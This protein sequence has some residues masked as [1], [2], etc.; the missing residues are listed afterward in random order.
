MDYANVAAADMAAFLPKHFDGATVI[1]P[2]DAT[3]RTR[4][5]R[6]LISANPHGRG[7]DASLTVSDTDGRTILWS[8][9]WN[10]SDAG[11]VDLRQEISRS[12]SRAALCLTEARGGRERLVQPALGLFMGGCVGIGDPQWSDADVLATF[13]RVV[14]LA[15]AFPRGW[16]YLAVGRAVAVQDGSPAASVKSARQAI[17]MARKLNPQSGMAYLAEEM[18]IPDDLA[19]VLALLEKGAELEP[20]NAMIQLQRAEAL[21]AFGRLSDSVDAATRAVELDPLSSFVRSEYI[22]TLTYAGRFSRAAA[23]IAEAHKNWPND[24]TIDFADFGFQYRY[25]D[26]RAAEKL[27]PRVLDYSDARLEPYRKLIAARLDPSPAK[28]DEAIR[29]WEGPSGGGNRNRFLLAL[30]QFHRVDET[31]VLLDDP[32]FQSIVDPRILFRPEFAPVRADPR[33]M[34]VAARLGLVRYWRE[35]GNWPD[36]CTTEQLKYDCEA[37]AAK[38]AKG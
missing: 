7:V 6:M 27:M 36:F 26:P 16:A 10:V 29:T 21:M 8:K 22:T 35:S 34:A 19:R 24:P 3:V 37:E 33:F 13:D 18:L 23:E 4:G 28:I 15:P 30:G 2:S 31:F 11:S 12:A 1:A 20:D 5:N 38:F 14:K 17:A 9:S 25:G 32:Q